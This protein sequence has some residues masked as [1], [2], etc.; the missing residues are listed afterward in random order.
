MPT[1]SQTI[2]EKLHLFKDTPELKDEHKTNYCFSTDVSISLLYI[3]TI[4][5][6][7]IYLLY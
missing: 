1:L 3:F 4:N 7:L 5:G 2:F 6:I